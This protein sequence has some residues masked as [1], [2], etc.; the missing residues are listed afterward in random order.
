MGKAHKYRVES[1]R[2][3]VFDSNEITG[4]TVSHAN[5]LW[6]E[7][8]FIFTRFLGGGGSDKY[9]TFTQTL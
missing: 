7:I 1:F 9:I 8:I 3:A 6:T 2:V 5:L 4:I